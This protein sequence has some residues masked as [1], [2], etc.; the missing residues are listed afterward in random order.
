MPYVPTED[1]PI[2]RNPDEV[3]WWESALAGIGSGIIKIPQGF[4]SLGATLYD[5]TGDHNTAK[6]VDQWFDEHNPFHDDAK[7]R[8][9]GR[10]TEAITELAP[11]GIG[12][13]SVGARIGARA[14]KG[15]EEVNQLSKVKLGLEPIE[16]LSGKTFDEI[17][18][19][20]NLGKTTEEITGKSAEE[21][22]SLK[23]KITELANN[24]VEAKK[25]GRYLSLSQLGQKIAN[26]AVGGVLGSAIGES[27]VADPDIGTFADMLRGTSLEPYALTMMDTQEKDGREDAYRRLL[28]RVKFG[29]ESALFTTALTGLGQ[30]INALIKPVDEYSPNTVKRFIQ[31]KMNLSSQG[32]LPTNYFTAIKSG[33]SGVKQTQTGLMLGT[34]GKLLDMTQKI[35]N[36]PDFLKATQQDLK[37]TFENTFELGN[38]QIALNTVIP[39]AYGK[40]INMKELAIGKQA[41]TSYFNDVYTNVLTAQNAKFYK[42]N[43]ESGYVKLFDSDIKKLTEEQKKTIIT[44]NESLLN[45]TAP[46]NITV[47]EYKPNPNVNVY[48]EIPKDPK[49]LALLSDEQKA[50]IKS[51]IIK[52]IDA[53]ILQNKIATYNLIDNEN[54]IYKLVTD[55]TKDNFVRLDLNNDHFIVHKTLDKESLADISQQ[56]LKSVGEYNGRLISEDDIKSLPNEEK[57]KVKMIGFEE[58]LN[59]KSDYVDAKTILANKKNLPED[60]QKLLNF[61][62]KGKV[63]LEDFINT[64]VDLRKSVDKQSLN[65]LFTGLNEEDFNKILGNLG[66]YLRTSYDNQKKLFPF[67]KNKVSDFNFNKAVT[68][69]LETKY[70]NFLKDLPEEIKNDPIKLQEELNKLKNESVDE[71]KN[72]V[73][74]STRQV[75]EEERA[76]KTTKD[77]I[78]NLPLDKSIFDQKLLSPN[79]R[80]ARNVIS[81]PIYNALESSGKIASVVN[82]NNSLKK[83]LNYG[84]TIKSISEDLKDAA[85]NIIKDEKGN[86]IKQISF[87]DSITGQKQTAQQFL[88]KNTFFSPEDFNNLIEKNAIKKGD[89]LNKLKFKKAEA[90]P[91]LEG[92]NPLE[93]MYV[94]SP[95]Y[96]DLFKVSSNFLNANP[97]GILYKNAILGPKMLSQLSKTILSPV[98]HFRNF[99]TASAYAFANG[100]IFPNY[101]DIQ[102]LL[103]E[104]L[105]G[106][107]LIGKVSGL[108]LKKIRGTLTE[109][110][111][112]EFKRLINVDVIRSQV[113]VGQLAE[114]AGTFKNPNLM[115]AKFTQ[116]LANPTAKI[117]SAFKRFED[118][119]TTEDD[120]WKMITWGLERNRINNA[121]TKSIEDGGLGINQYNY[122]QRLLGNKII[123]KDGNTI[124]LDE[125]N[126]FNDLL[127]RGLVKPEDKSAYKIVD[128]FNKPLSS[129]P[130]DALKIYQEELKGTKYL[131]SLSNLN[132][133]YAL[134]SFDN[135]LDEYAGSLA[136][137]QIPNYSYTSKAAKLFRLSPFGNFIAFPMEIMRTGSNIY[138]QAIR[139]I[140]SGIPEL[141]AIGR[142]RLISFGTMI[143]GV[144]IAMEQAYS[145]LYDVTDKEMAALRR[146]IPEWSKNSTLIPWGRDD[147]GY[148]KYK[149]FDYANPYAFLLKPYNAIVSNVM[150]GNEDNQ[151]LMASFNKG[152]LEATKDILKPFS[153]ESLWTE[154]LID[155]VL[156]QGVGQNGKRIWNEEDDPFVKVSK[157]L[158]HLGDS[159]TPGSIA[160]F[161]RLEEAARGKADDYGRTFNLQDELPGLYGFRTIQSDPEDALKF[162][163]STFANKIEK[164]RSLFTNTLLKEGRLNPNDILKNYQYS[165]ARRFEN[166]KEMYID[167]QALKDLGVPDATIIKQLKS[168]KGVDE[169]TLKSLMNGRY[170]PSKPAADLDQKTQQITNQLNQKEGTIEP[171]PYIQVKPEINQM[172]N[173]NSGLNLLNDY[174]KMPKFLP[175]TQPL[176]NTNQIGQRLPTP[177]VNTFGLTPVVNNITQTNSIASKPGFAFL[178]PGEQA[179]ELNRQQKQTGQ[180]PQQTVAGVNR[181]T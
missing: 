90:F 9:I 131:Q 156:G 58:P 35:V 153:S 39:N 127:E 12:G 80:Y 113:E 166:M 25:E 100:A 133:D 177:S 51:K 104:F 140:T 5:L 44:K 163:S 6:E 45:K 154:A 170:S 142:R 64:T 22:N 21:I 174:L 138:Q 71:M 37:Q 24:A 10:I 88:D 108:N 176:T 19:L 36:D 69:T 18:R 175:L 60:F 75:E 57:S 164:D 1:Q 122:R 16:R 162:K 135:F 54:G 112:N 78:S 27:V 50:T 173:N 103:P 178:S 157:S 181:I 79:L 77:E 128:A 91:D 111:I 121:M 68:L 105:G 110:D 84:T 55:P 82:V 161:K 106:Q 14:L 132:K 72:F 120:F 114:L 159:L 145:A 130:K 144:P 152:L 96:D 124:T 99:V 168:H 171:N 160:Q 23:Q 86:P 11:L 49:E 66:S 107:G 139:E 125:Y 115:D 118:I 28:N 146:I 83:V 4:V 169:R 52:T 151:S 116:S 87:Y 141:A 2:K 48:K 56:N 41:A 117:Q 148:L 74:Q 95:I 59:P 101:G 61:A 29:T 42:P 155:S 94:K 123:D 136:R 89:I 15:L 97:V 137:N 149:D 167:I 8:T 98:T 38:K 109:S 180:N 126:K 26:P 34:G 93:G 158:F 67:I 147:K 53:P 30:G 143:A 46:L 179:Y 3:P 32:N 33:E 40:P 165:E 17:N 31:Q 150:R 62:E 63:N 76:A 119:Y 20:K 172:I 47:E 134:S 65:L 70:K 81:N 92:I 7:A 129:N 43:P 13:A 85:G 102:M 73:Q